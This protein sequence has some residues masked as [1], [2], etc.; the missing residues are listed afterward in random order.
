MK[1]TSLLVHFCIASCLVPAALGANYSVS[2]IADTN[3]GTCDADCSLREAVAAANATA[4]ND[5]I[6]FAL[7]FF[8]SPRTI[9]LTAGEIVFANNGTLT[10]Y[11]TGA[12]RLTISGNGAS[13]IFASGANVVANLHHLRF[14]GGNGAGSVNTGRGGAVYNVGG[15]MVIT[16]SVFSGNSAANGGALNNAASASPSVPA[17]LTL[18][19]CWVT[20]NSSTSSGSAMQNFS[21]STLTLI[22]TS[23]TN[24]TSSGTGIAGAVQ[25]NGTVSITNSTFSGNTAPSG[26]GGGVYYNGSSL[27]MT[28]STLANNSSSLGGGG[29]H[30]TGTTPTLIMRNTIAANNAGAAAT[31]DVA[32]LVSSEGNNIIGNIGTSTGWVGSDL[33]NTNPVL[34]PVGSY[35][36][37]GG[38]H[39]ALT[40]SPALNGGQNCVKDLTCATNN[41]PVAVSSDQRGALRTDTVDIGS[42][43][44]SS[45][46]VATLPSALV[47]Q[48]YNHVLSP[49]VGSF[50]YS[51]TS[52]T[53]PPG[54]T[55]STG[56]VVAIIAGTPTQTGTSDFGVTVTNGSNSAVV[57][58][59]ST[60]LSNASVIP[61]IGR[62][63][64]VSGTGISKAVVVLTDQ[65]GGSRFVLTNGVGYFVFPDLTAGATYTVSIAS[66]QYTF[67][68]QVMTFADATTNLTLT[69]N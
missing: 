36:G 6:Y 30:R 38:S 63:V 43:E 42:T 49:N 31:P 68:P 51:Q 37:I 52:G 1:F 57:N 10:I 62:V 29:L 7:P 44:S 3:D 34:S 64:N 50:T 2:K 25:A 58:Y 59:Q 39:V 56:S 32:G 28:N 27:I 16:N 33:Q 4:A 60:V 41:P 11:G 67:T 65:N 22:N 8:A 66:K 12:N 15:T 46:F 48:P 5:S 18:N 26:T 53:L 54:L 61:V 17:N 9:I 45:D 13:R 47:N 69:V 19:N 23:V 14:T 21:T 24:N 20:N 35:G 40:G 55:V